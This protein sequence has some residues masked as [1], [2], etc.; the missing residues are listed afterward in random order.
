MLEIGEEVWNETRDTWT[1]PN[2]LY[3]CAI[4]YVTVNILGDHWTSLKI[5]I[6]YE[7]NRSFFPLHFILL[8]NYIKKEIM[9][10][11]DDTIN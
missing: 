7:S 4:K 6:K 1:V 9:N 11:Y 10:F 8:Q 2:V 3:T 5:S